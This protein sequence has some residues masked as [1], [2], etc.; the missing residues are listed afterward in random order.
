[1]AKLD[2]DDQNAWISKLTFPSG[3]RSANLVRGKAKEDLHADA[4]DKLGKWYGSSRLTAQQKQEV[5]PCASP[6]SDSWAE[7]EPKIRETRKHLHRLDC[8]SD[9]GR[10]VSTYTQ[11]FPPLSLESGWVAAHF[12]DV[13]NGDERAPWKLEVEGQP[14]D[15]G[16]TSHLELSLPWW[17]RR[18]D[19]L[20]GS[21]G[22]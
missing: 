11:M 13:P 6:C 5:M 20:W 3:V 7:K 22:R 17:C 2:P 8:A 1:M 18:N 15:A 19:H 10:A 12:A 4:N 14:F 21:F 16:T 9:L